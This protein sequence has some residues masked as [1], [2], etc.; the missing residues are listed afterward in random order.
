MERAAAVDVLQ[1]GGHAGVSLKE[2]PQHSRGSRVAI[3]VDDNESSMQ[4]LTWAMLHVVKAGDEVHVVRVQAPTQVYGALPFPGASAFVEMIHGHVRYENERSKDVVRH[5]QG[6]C[7][8][9][10]DVDVNGL[11]VKGDSEE[12]LIDAV[13]A[14]QADFLVV[15]SDDV[16]Y[17]SVIER[18]FIG[19]M[20]AYLLENAP[21]PVL[22]VNSN[23]RFR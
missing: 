18:L 4:A 13:L 9:L 14:I 11:V 15:A 6:M 1:Y 22:V 10:A 12:G 23:C 7:R 17:Q 5:A 19:S 2:A 8:I 21:C 16:R 20:N 3:A